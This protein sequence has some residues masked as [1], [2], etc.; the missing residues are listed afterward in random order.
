MARQFA[1][2]TQRLHPYASQHLPNWFLDLSTM[3]RMADPGMRL[4][5]SEYSGFAHEGAMSPVADASEQ[6][7]LPINILSD[8]RDRQQ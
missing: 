1:T 4:F 3:R 2:L 7:E 8:W 5:L 6:H